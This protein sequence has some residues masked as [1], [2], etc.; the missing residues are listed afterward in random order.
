MN[1]LDELR[2]QKRLIEDQIS[3]EEFKQKKLK[4]LTDNIEI[5]INPDCGG[6]TAHAVN[7]AG[8]ALNNLLC[9]KG[10]LTGA[11][12]NNL[13]PIFITVLNRYFNELVNTLE[14]EG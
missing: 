1:K 11:Q 13:K 2:E 9:E 5:L 12:F 7:E 10:S 8:W 4:L 6:V 14:E 3:E